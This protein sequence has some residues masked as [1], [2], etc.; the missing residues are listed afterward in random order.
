[1]NLTCRDG[2]VE[3]VRDVFERSRSQMLQVEDAELVRAK[4]LTIPIYSS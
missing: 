3:E 1:M 4:G 2:E